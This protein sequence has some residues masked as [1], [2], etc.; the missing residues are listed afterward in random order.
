MSTVVGSWADGIDGSTLSYHYIVSYGLYSH[1]FLSK[2]K[3]VAVKHVNKESVVDVVESLVA[4]W[5]WLPLH[6]NQSSILPPLLLYLL[7]YKKKSVVDGWVKI[8]ENI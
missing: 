8:Q 4:Q 1:Y 7:N 6:K 2:K 3:S 5:H